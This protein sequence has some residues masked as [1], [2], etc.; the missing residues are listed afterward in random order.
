MTLY[1]FGGA[2]WPNEDYGPRH[3]K[4]KFGGELVRFGRYR[5][6]FSPIRMKM[7]EAAYDATRRMSRP[8]YWRHS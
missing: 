4:K 6:V 7:A 8:S 5:K 2:G 3:F 1:D